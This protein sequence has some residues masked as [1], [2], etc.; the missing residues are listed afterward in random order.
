MELTFKLS[1]VL[2]ISLVQPGSWKQVMFSNSHQCT[3]AT[4]DVTSDISHLSLAQPQPEIAGAVHPA[5]S[6]DTESE[7][8]CQHKGRVA[9]FAG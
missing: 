5:A 9:G 8:K 6:R 7:V 2:T 1:L 3:A 4:G